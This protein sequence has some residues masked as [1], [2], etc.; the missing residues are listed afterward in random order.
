MRHRLGAHESISGG[1]SWAIE[2]G[3]AVG[4]DVIQIFTKSNHQWSGGT[5]ESADIE[6]FRARA[7]ETGI[8]VVA[9][10]ASYL[11]NLASP[12]RSLRRKSVAAL[13][14]EIARCD[15]LGIPNLVIHPGAHV[16]SGETAGLRAIVRSLNEA[17]SRTDA[18]V[19]VCLEST[20]GQGS[21]L[22]YC[23]EHLS[24]IL[25]EANSA[26][27]TRL[28]VC[29]DTCHLFAAGYDLRDPDRCETTIGDI[30]R[31]V[32]SAQLKVIHLNDSQGTLGSRKDRHAHIGGGELGLTGFENVLRDD[33]LAAVPMILETP[34]EEDLVEDLLNLLLLRSLVDE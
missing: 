26:T 2:R 6:L 28:G 11:I 30:I 13:V 29:L 9:S 10:H 20:T 1:L 32:G 25:N 18:G 7:V 22:G 4:A 27:A 5:Y 19:C 12:D 8:E 15:Q 24:Q 21:T 33:R 31:L 23:L 34:K 16:G 14:D 3:Y 17:L